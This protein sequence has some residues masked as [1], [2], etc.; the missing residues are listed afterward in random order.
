M[1]LG[2]VQSTNGLDYILS[3]RENIGILRLTFHVNL[4]GTKQF[5]QVYRARVG[6]YVVTC[7]TPRYSVK[8]QNLFLL[9]SETSRV[10]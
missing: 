7:F 9:A 2:K 6:Q 1:P 3:V 10:F 8:S 5:F 4:Q